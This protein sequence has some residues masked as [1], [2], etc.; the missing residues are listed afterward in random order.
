MCICTF[1][2]IDFVHFW[3]FYLTFFVLGRILFTQFLFP[4][5]FKVIQYAQDPAVPPGR[6]GIPAMKNSVT[7]QDIANALQMSR[8]TVSKAL[9]GKD[10]PLKTRNAVINMAIEMGYKG[11]KLAAAGDTALGHK[12]IAL[13]SS[14]LLMN[15]NYYI[16]VLRGVEESL[17][18]Y[19]I[20]LAQFNVTTPTSFAKFRHYLA[21]NKVDGILCIEFFEPEYITELLELGQPLIFLDFPLVHDPL[22]GKYDIILPESMSSVKNFC[23]QMIREGTCRTFGFVGDYLHCRSFYERFLGMREALFLSG[24][25]VDLKYSIL[26]DD[27]TP[28]GA[29][30][31]EK[32]LQAL[33]ALPDC[34][35]AANDTIAIELL[36]ALKSMK[37]HVPKE[38]KVMGFDNIPEARSTTPPLS[39]FYVNKGALGKMITNVMLERIAHPMQSNQ[40]IYIAS[41]AV[42]RSTT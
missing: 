37:I 5:P 33:P 23:M 35:I 29:K 14:R 32:A 17:S 36:G 12:R 16:Y 15:I 18:N 24:L 26:K 13:L 42:L 38:V 4:C 30:D 28:Y 2:V 40:I 21:N 20:E 22:K 3:L 41:K 34:F 7:I 6:K 39:S 1:Y 11:Y 19:D 25:P 27:S 31:L 8:N 10:V 9:N